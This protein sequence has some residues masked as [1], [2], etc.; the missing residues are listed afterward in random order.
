MLFR[1]FPFDFNSEFI[2]QMLEKKNS[3]IEEH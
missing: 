3:S 1:V 2:K